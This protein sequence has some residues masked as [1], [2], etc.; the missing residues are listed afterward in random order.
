MGAYQKDTGANLK[1]RSMAN[2]ESNS[3]KMKVLGYN[4]KNEVNIN[5]FILT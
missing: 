5:E 1:E 2:P 4:Q 3:N